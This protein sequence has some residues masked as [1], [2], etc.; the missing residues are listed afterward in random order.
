MK[1]VNVRKGELLKVLR[2]N[3]ET[4]IKEY[5]SAMQVYKEDVLAKLEEMLATAKEEMSKDKPKFKLNVNLAEPTSYVDSYDTAIRMLE[6]STDDKI[7]L[8]NQEFSQYVEDNWSW[9]NTFSLVTGSY[10]S[11]LA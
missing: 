4:H 9:K 6:M 10:N 8:S 11:K 3:R 7:E 5:E 2:D 1:S